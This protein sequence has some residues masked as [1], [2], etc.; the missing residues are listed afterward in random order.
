VKV[1]RKPRSVQSQKHETQ[2]RLR[3]QEFHGWRC[4]IFTANQLQCCEN[5]CTRECA[6]GEKH[7]HDELTQQS[8]TCINSK[9]SEEIEYNLQKEEGPAKRSQGLAIFTLR[10]LG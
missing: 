1:V 6:G 10:R 4:Q 5:L 9:I 7:E 2:G 3:K 8:G